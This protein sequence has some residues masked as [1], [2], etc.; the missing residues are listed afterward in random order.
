MTQGWVLGLSGPGFQNLEQSSAGRW[1]LRR[2]CEFLTHC[3]R[4]PVSEGLSR[5]EVTEQVCLARGPGAPALLGARRGRPLRGLGREGR[6]PESLRS[7]IC[8]P[9][10]GDW[11]AVGVPR[12]LMWPITG[13]QGVSSGC[14]GRG[15]S[16]CTFVWGPWALK[17]A[18]CSP[19][20]DSCWVSR[21]R[22]GNRL[23]T[24]AALLGGRHA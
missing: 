4:G 3:S 7:C 13:D 16:A 20:E 12:E 23:G 1:Y 17:S 18:L 14:V 19:H 24:G 8:S 9:G 6:S 5:Q 11:G 22:Q 15:L 21:L 10:C 2:V